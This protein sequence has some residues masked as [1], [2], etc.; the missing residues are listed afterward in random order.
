[1]K[2]RALLGAA[3][4]PYFRPMPVTVHVVAHTHWDREWYHPAARFGIRLLRLV[5]DLLDFLPRHPDFRSFLLDGQAIVLDDYLA[6]RPEHEE[7]LRRLFGEGR[8][9]AGPWYVLADEFLVSAEALVRNLLAGQ[10]TVRRL[11]GEPMAVGYSP[12]AFGHPA[13]LPTLFAGFGLPTAVL[14]RGFGGEPGQEGDLH[15]IGRA[16]CRE[17]VLELV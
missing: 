11:G 2:L 14:W 15:Q 12:D 3:S 7:R 1:M 4:G 6:A 17:R 10:R 9:E 13:A 16:S 8:L 5:D